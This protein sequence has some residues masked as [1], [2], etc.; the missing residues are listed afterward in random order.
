MGQA[1]FKRRAEYSVSF[2]QERRIFLILAADFLRT[3]VFENKEMNKIINKSSEADVRAE[4]IKDLKTYLGNRK[5]AKQELDAL[6]WYLDNA[7]KTHGVENVIRNNFSKPVFKVNHSTVF[8]SPNSI[9]QKENRKGGIVRNY[10]DGYGN[11]YKQIADNEEHHRK[12]NFDVGGVHAHN[13]VLNNGGIPTHEDVRRLSV[14]E[15]LENGD[16]IWKQLK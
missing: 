9:T 13:Y 16:L 15:I 6:K 4:D 1:F 8:G 14:K 5:K 7:D 2:V 3:I 11:Q 12:E 10:Y